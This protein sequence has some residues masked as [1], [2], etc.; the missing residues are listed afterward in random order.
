[1]GGGIL[2]RLH[3]SQQLS[4]ARSLPA[5]P[6]RACHC[7]Y[8]TNNSYIYGFTIYVFRYSRKG[9]QGGRPSGWL[10]SSSCLDVAI[11]RVIEVYGPSIW[12]QATDLDRVK[13][14][15]RR[16]CK[17]RWEKSAKPFIYAFIY[18]LHN[19]YFRLCLAA[20]LLT[21]RRANQIT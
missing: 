5:D 11:A 10:A 20:W 12:C 2:A 15:C 13:S 6:S 8:N 3:H 1:M 16:R 17:C 9:S 4:A 14:R 7:Q 18:T 19:T 21:C